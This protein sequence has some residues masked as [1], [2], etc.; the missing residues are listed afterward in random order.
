MN[1]S[2]FV[3][4][5]QEKAGLDSKAQ[6]EKSVD[7]FLSVLSGALASGDSVNFVGFGGFK[8]TPR[9]ARKGRNPQTGKEIDIPAS[10]VVKFTP[11]KALK[12]AVK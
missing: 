10:K 8:V 3:A 7:A 1:K 9:P 6:A 11:G 2:E 4:A 12:D 5:L